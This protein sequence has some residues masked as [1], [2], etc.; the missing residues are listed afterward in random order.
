M[1]NYLHHFECQSFY[2]NFGLKMSVGCIGEHEDYDALTTEINYDVE[3]LENGIEYHI[4]PDTK[5]SEWYFGI[6]W[7]DNVVINDESDK[8]IDRDCQTWYAADPQLRYN[9]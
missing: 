4:Y 8:N 1:K 7:I 3:Y 6:A 5:T 9:K 2:N